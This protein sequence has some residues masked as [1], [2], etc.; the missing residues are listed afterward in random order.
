[1]TRERK[2]FFLEVFNSIHSFMTIVENSYMKQPGCNLFSFFLQ[3]LESV[4][5]KVYNEVCPWQL[6]TW[7][8]A[9]TSGGVWVLLLPV[10]TLQESSCNLGHLYCIS[11]DKM[12]RVFVMIQR[13]W[14][15]LSCGSRHLS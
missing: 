1:L 8:W 10:K 3:S 11:C 5:Y 12:K 14:L 13:T 2:N 15:W 6:C 4:V 9:V 7:F